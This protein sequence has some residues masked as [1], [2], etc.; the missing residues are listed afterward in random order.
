MS[1]ASE[2]LVASKNPSTLR[3]F[4]L[5]HLTRAALGV[6][7]GV[8]A[9]AS[10]TFTRTSVASC[11]TNADCRG[12]FGTGMVCGAEGICDRGPVNPRCVVTEPEDLFTRPENYKGA[13]IIGAMMDRSVEAQRAREN[14]IRLAARQVRE[15]GG[16]DGTIFGVVFCD[17]AK[18]TVYDGLERT[19]AAVASSRYLADTIGVSAIVGPS[20]SGDALAVFN[21]VK[22]FDVVD[23]SPAATSPSLTDAEPGGTDERPGLLWR[24]APPDTLQG[25]AIVT[26][27][28]NQFA[29]VSQ[30]AVIQEAGAYGDALT[31]VFKQGFEAGGGKTV[32]VFP[33]SNAP[34]RDEAIFD[35]GSKNPPVVLFIS[36]QTKDSIDFLNIAGSNANYATTQFFLTDAAATKELATSA[37]ANLFERVSGSRPAVPTGDTFNLFKSSFI[38][39]FGVDPGAYSFV[40]HSYD[41]AWLAFYGTAWAERREGKVTG[42][43]I[44][45]GLRKLS[46]GGPEVR[47]SPGNWL[48]IV[49]TLGGGNSVNLSGASGTLDYDA[50]TEETTG[51]V[52]IWKISADRQITVV[53]TLDP[54]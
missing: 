7:V 50:A 37:P 19:A 29:S 36:S 38:G 47:V 3:S 30:V 14:A 4:G 42:T 39:A 20:A 6:V 24:T 28:A 18:N 15:V 25:A 40:P 48:D 8:A 5:G 21:E 9:L 49:N 41:A 26:R 2:N 53:E 10:C 33:Y 31:R 16:L 12:A 35:A 54:R 11:T 23:I 44:A 46:S 1:V 32:T 45:R 27:V 17:V 22:A 13:H 43:G 51:R 52:D 34:Q